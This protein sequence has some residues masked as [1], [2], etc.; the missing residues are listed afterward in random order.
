MIRSLL[1]LQLFVLC[2]IFSWTCQP[3]KAQDTLSSDSL[4]AMIDAPTQFTQVPYFTFGKGLGLISP[5][6]V[7]ALN[8]RFRIQNRAVFNFNDGDPANI[9]G[10]VRRLR[11]RFDGFVYHPRVTYVIQLSFTPEDMDW[12]RT[13]FPNILRDAMIFYKVNK[14]LTLGLG[15]TKLPGNRQRVNSSGDLQFVDRSIVNATLNVDRDFGIQAKYARQLKNKFHYVLLG[16]ISTGKGRNFFQEVSEL[17]YTGRIE[18]LP[19][20]LFEAFGDYFEGD[21]MREKTPKLS[22]GMTLNQNYNTLRTGG[23]IGVLLYQPTDMT[24]YMSDWLFKYRGFAFASEFLYRTSENPLTFNDENDVR[25]VYNGL[26]QNFQASYLLPND[27]EFAGRYTRLN[28]RGQVRL[29]EPD[30]QHITVGLTRYLRGHRLKLQSDFTYELLGTYGERP[31][32]AR[33]NFIWRFQVE[34]GI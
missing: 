18:L 3:L 25:Y 12:E 29:Y 4:Q 23:Q 20:G 1:S 7:F 10:K 22:I 11:L 6:S 5:D 26:G 34:L 31:N 32:P 24:T 13:Q 16:A 9:E 21:L 27:L 17:S 30:L 15:Q 8:I 14:N 28:P 33:N 2:F 19:F